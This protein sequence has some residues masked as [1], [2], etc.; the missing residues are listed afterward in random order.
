MQFRLRG[1][2]CDY[3]MLQ[4]EHFTLLRCY[5]HCLD[6][7]GF[8]LSLLNSIGLNFGYVLFYLFSQGLMGDGSR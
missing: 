1:R 7:L 6:S 8:L 3:C 4:F 2:F 5:F